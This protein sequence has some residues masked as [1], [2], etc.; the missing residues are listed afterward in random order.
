MKKMKIFLFLFATLTFANT[1]GQFSIDF[2]E[3]KCYNFKFKSVLM[4][5]QCFKLSYALNTAANVVLARVDIYGNATIFSKGSIDTKEIEAKLSQI[6]TVK[7]TRVSETPAL[8]QEFLK[9]YALFTYPE[10]SDY[11]GESFDVINFKDNIRQESV[12][13]LAKSIWVSMYPQEYQKMIPE[14]VEQTAIEKTEKAA[15]ESNIDFKSKI[16]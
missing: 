10:K 16:K 6:T 8:Q 13:G 3:I 7:H 9:T 4:A 11:K 15:K 14:Q 5:D 2:S 1:F 12:F